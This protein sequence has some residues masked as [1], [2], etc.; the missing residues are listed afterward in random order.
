MPNSISKGSKPAIKGYVLGR[1]SFARISAV[2]GIRL[3]PAMEADFREFDR[4]GLSAPQRRIT[5]S[6]SASS[7]AV[8]RRHDYEL[9][10]ERA[11]ARR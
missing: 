9:S 4:K 3:S 6:R 2:E 11:S 5:R 1:A 8:S 7:E 10:W